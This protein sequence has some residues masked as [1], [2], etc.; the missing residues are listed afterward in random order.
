MGFVLDGV[1]AKGEDGR[2]A[3]YSKGEINAFCLDI[4]AL[5]PC[6]DRTGY[7]AAYVDA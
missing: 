7:C 2:W 4:V 6:E 5:A 1:V 3:P